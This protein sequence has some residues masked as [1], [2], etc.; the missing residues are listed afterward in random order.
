MHNKPNYK[1]YSLNELRQVLQRIDSEKYP[2]RVKEIKE[3]IQ[4][5]EKNPTE[6]DL[7]NLESEKEKQEFKYFN[8]IY[9]GGVILILLLVK[10]QYIINPFI[11]ISNSVFAAIISIGYIFLSIASAGIATWSIKSPTFIAL[12]IISLCWFIYWAVFYKSLLVAFSGPII[13]ILTIGRFM[14]CKKCREYW[15]SKI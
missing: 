3:Q 2:D 6:Q 12:N 15:K 7:L 1:E 14:A 8:L 9:W 4:I 10:Q 11:E 5:H 13:F